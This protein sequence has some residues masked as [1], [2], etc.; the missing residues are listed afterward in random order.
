M[1]RSFCCT[2]VVAMIA[3]V[4]AA[5]LLTAVRL[6]VSFFL[7]NLTSSLAGP[8]VAK[9][10]LCL[11]LARSLPLPVYLISNSDLYCGRASDGVKKIRV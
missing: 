8:Y 2:V 6:V 10:T 5:G 4:E 7:P 3:A 1:R 9:Q 11:G